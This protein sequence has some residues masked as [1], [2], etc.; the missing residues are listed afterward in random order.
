[1]PS[2]N[3]GAPITVQTETTPG[4]YLFHAIGNKRLTEVPVTR[5]RLSIDGGLDESINP[6]SFTQSA[7]YWL[8]KT[9]GTPVGS[10]GPLHAVSLTDLSRSVDVWDHHVTPDKVGEETL[11][12]ET[13]SGREQIKGLVQ[14][15]L[16]RA[17]PTEFYSFNLLDEVVRKNIE[18]GGDEYAFAA[19]RKYSAK[20]HITANGAVLLQVESGHTLTTTGTLDSIITEGE[21]FSNKLVEHDMSVYDN[22]GSGVAIGWSDK[23]YRDHVDSVGSSICEYHEGVLNGELRQN[24]KEQNP[25]LVKVR[26]GGIVGQQLPHILKLSPRTEQVEQEDWDFHQLFT[27]RRAMEPAERF[28]YMKDFVDDLAPLPGFGIKVHAGPSNHGY[29]FTDIRDSP[30]NLVFHNGHR[31]R[32]PKKGLLQAGAYKSPG[33][34]RLSVLYPTNFGDL[35]QD[36]IELLVQNLAR[37]KAPAG[38]TGV[39]YELGETTEYTGVFQDLPDGTDVVV[40]LEPNEGATD[41][42]PGVE[43]P[44]HEIKRTLMRQ[45]IPT[46]MVQKGTAQDILKTSQRAPSNSF[47]NILSGIIAKAGGTP[48]QIADMPGTTQAFMGLD[49]TRDDETGQHSG[50]SASI[51]MRDGSTF[52]AESTTQQAGEKF[53][54]DS[55]GQFVRD[56]AF[57]IAEEQG[58]PLDHICLMRDGIVHEEVE[59]IRD[60]LS[61]LDAEIDVVG[62]RKRGQTRVAEFDG[63]SFKIADKGIAFADQ[64]RDE[65]IL[66]SFGKPEI[67]DDNSVGTPRTLRLVKHSGPTDIET[68]TKQ[69]YWLSE[70]HYGSA[71]RS[72]RLPVPIKYAD[73][74][75]EYVREGYVSPGQV[76][77]GPAYL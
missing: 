8:D 69:A 62:I 53:L 18:F 54:S 60:G 74:A 6:Q 2:D 63:T 23:H 67:G 24:Y 11:T 70:V 44:H 27:S 37:W 1:M 42:F 17:I 56:L 45:G 38:T 20:V 55:I 77:R 73:M 22:Q 29:K 14:S 72:T 25:R 34:Y 12:P 15:S 39:T 50:A 10:S 66:H 49:V 40:A 7:V 32:N 71:A 31:T 4:P 47:L 28:E 43:D 19:Q 64:D 51:V 52:A 5:Y 13:K 30:K 48:W 16:R 61:S 65:S 59:E 3:F 68:L 58:T 36:F 26:Y 41:S 33:K 35:A 9:H 57:D 76:I 21:D 75:A 46:Q